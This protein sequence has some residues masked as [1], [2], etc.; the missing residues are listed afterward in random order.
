VHRSTHIT[1]SALALGA[2]LFAVS[3]P[4]ARGQ[5]ALQGVT[6]LTGGAGSIKSVTV[7]VPGRPSALTNILELVVAL[8]TDERMVPQVIPDA[9]TVNVVDLLGQQ[10]AVVVTA[11]ITGFVWRP[12]TPGTVPLAATAISAALVAFPTLDPLRETTAAYRVRVELPPAF[13]DQEI[14]VTMDLF[15]N[16]N[17]FGSTA[18]L[19]TVALVPEPATALLVGV[20]VLGLVFRRRS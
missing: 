6:L 19:G 3:G 8:A 15:D 9:V 12:E 11:D 20:G 5:G 7:D 4:S 13:L 14:R 2:A 18:F 16:G 17:L 10:T 1:L